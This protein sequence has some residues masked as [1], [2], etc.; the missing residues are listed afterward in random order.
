MNQGISLDAWRIEE[1]IDRIT[2]ITDLLSKATNQNIIDFA[3]ALNTEFMERFGKEIVVREY[4]PVKATM[5]KMTMKVKNPLPSP[6]TK[7]KKTR[8][9]AKAK[10]AQKRWSLQ[11]IAT[12]RGFLIEKKIRHISKFS[13][14]KQKSMARKFGRS[15]P[16]VYLRARSLIQSMK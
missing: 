5:D 9:Q 11:E 3:M 12:L 4:E 6:E 14:A 7:P 15:R 13:L 2:K 10:R 16:A 1:E 8:R